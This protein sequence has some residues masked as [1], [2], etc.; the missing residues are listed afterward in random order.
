MEELEMNTSIDLTI[1]TPCYN[2]E[3]N[4][5]ECSE[6]IKTMM[7][8]HLPE[9]KYEH[10]FID[11]HSTDLTVEKIFEICKEDPNVK[12]LVNS[13]NVGAFKSIYMALQESSGR[14]VV[15]MFAADLQD[16]A[17]IIPQLFANWLEGYP[18]VFGVRANRKENLL[19]KSARTLYYV[20]IQKL[21]SSY[22]P[23]NAGEF[24]L[25]D[26][27][28]I[29]SIL[30][31]KDFEPY[32]RGMIASLGTESIEI[33]YNMNTRKKGK[34]K[35]SIFRLFDIALNGFISTT[36]VPARLVL[37]SGL[38]LSISSFLIIVLKI[39]I[40][41]ILS[42]SFLPN[43]NLNSY[44]ILGISGI[45]I[46]FLGLIGEYILSIHSQVRKSPEPFFIKRMNI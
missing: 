45:Q 1:I 34:S 35:T 43:L 28:I 20:L 7:I 24:L 4:V 10:I 29:D 26:R 41:G 15:P 16:P 31:T 12:L 21:S 17:E 38:V 23:V 6:S 5:I 33:K 40:S 30:A 3:D 2:E 8:N 42:I 13:K 46:F 32:I 44:L 11:N 22:I 25:A 14:A 27:K 36:K 39:I 18:T 37:L 19:L 9:I